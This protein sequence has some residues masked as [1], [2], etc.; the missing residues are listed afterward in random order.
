MGGVGRWRW[1]RRCRYSSTRDLR[2]RL[3]RYCH[4]RSRAISTACLVFGR[5]RVPL[6]W[7]LWTTTPG[8]FAPL[9]CTVECELPVPRSP[10]ELEFELEIATI[11][12]LDVQGCHPVDIKARGIPLHL[13]PPV[14][15]CSLTREDPNPSILPQYR[16]IYS[17]S[18]IHYTTLS[19]DTPAGNDHLQH[20]IADIAAY[21]FERHEL[22]NIAPTIC[23]Q[24]LSSAAISSGTD[25]HDRRSTNRR[26]ASE[27]SRSASN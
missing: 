22:A 6:L 10:D 23:C 25:T 17:T 2:D 18:H 8:P 1:Q 15:Q 13:L 21:F 3:S 12:F 14:S 16:H 24:W 20:C 11:R 4:S 27:L 9:L 26:F 5:S 19:V 7:R